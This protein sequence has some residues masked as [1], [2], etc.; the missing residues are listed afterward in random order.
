MQNQLN[1][2]NTSIRADDE[3]LSCWT[4]MALVKTIDM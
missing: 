1:N 4:L 2:H 3:R